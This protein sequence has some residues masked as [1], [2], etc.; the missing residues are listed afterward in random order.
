MNTSSIVSPDSLQA[1]AP[2]ELTASNA[3]AF[4]DQM[5][6]LLNDEPKVLAIDMSRTTF[7]DSSGLGALVGLQ[8]VAASWQGSLTLLDPLP[9]VRQII[10][11]TRLNRLFNVV[12][13]AT[14]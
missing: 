7:L 6:K 4:R 13:S 10:E 5:I 2:Q 3:A 8:K 11:L 12:T 9:A 1:Q 14:A